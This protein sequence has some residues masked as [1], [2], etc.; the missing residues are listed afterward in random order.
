MCTNGDPLQQVVSALD[1]LVEADAALCA[2]RDAIVALHRQL[3]RLEAVVTRAVGAFERERAWEADGAR[4]ASAWLAVECALPVRVAW[5]RVQVGRALRDLPVAEAAW[6]DGDLSGPAV[7]LL[8]DA[9]TEV[10][11]EAMERDE[12][13]LVDHAG[14]LSHG[15]FAKALAYWRQRAD[16]DGVEDDAEALHAGRRVH[17]SSTYEGRWVLDGVLDPVGGEIVA[18]ALGRITD[19][20]FRSDWAEAR[21]EHGDAT[22]KEHLAR[23]PAQRRADALVELARRAGAVAPGDKVPEPLFTVYV[24]H[25]TLTGRLC[26]LAGGTVVTP[27]TVAP[28]L[29]QAVVER[30]VFDGKDRVL[31]VG[32]RRRFFTGAERRAV[33]VRDR[34]C[35]NRYCEVLAERCEV[36]H[37]IPWALGGPT[38]ADNGQLACGYHNRLRE[39]APP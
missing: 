37:V 13:M 32:T 19:E 24:D 25:P 3:D 5:R 38:E 10:T 17:L 23:R 1:A 8:A 14:R 7:G 39:R 18:N 11:A 31:G 20:L 12:A 30:V 33:E 34:Q 21:A 36:D 2:D 35:T 15:S 6:L 9:R 27:G 16:P 28:W 29:D 26:E 4:T 22:T